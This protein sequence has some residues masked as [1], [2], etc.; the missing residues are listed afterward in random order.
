MKMV[1]LRVVTTCMIPSNL[2]FS[3][4]KFSEFQL[5]SYWK[6]AFPEN[7]TFHINYNKLKINTI[8]MHLV[9]KWIWQS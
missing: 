2:K 7:V 8:H 5:A 3:V 4:Y 6:L 1:L 9:F